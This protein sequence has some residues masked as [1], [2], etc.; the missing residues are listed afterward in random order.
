MLMTRRFSL[1]VMFFYAYR[2]GHIK[3]NISPKQMT[4]IEQTCLKSSVEE[5]YH[6][7]IVIYSELRGTHPTQNEPKP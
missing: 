7:H 5:G 4:E 2:A 6:R 3:Q 1:P